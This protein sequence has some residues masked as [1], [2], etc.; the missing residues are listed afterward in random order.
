MDT[1]ANN[2]RIDRSPYEVI[3]RDPSR[4]EYRAMR[5]RI[6]ERMVRAIFAAGVDPKDRMAAVE[7]IRSGSFHQQA[8][9]RIGPVAMRLAERASLTNVLASRG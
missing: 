1:N 3:I 8:I 7:A 2:K 6:C 5:R 9:E 4:P